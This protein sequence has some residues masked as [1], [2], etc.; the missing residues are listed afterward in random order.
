[1]KTFPRIIVK[2]I[3][4]YYNENNIIQRSKQKET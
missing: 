1:M 4:R 2:V 3:C